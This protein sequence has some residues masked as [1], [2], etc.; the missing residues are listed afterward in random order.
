[1]TTKSLCAALL[2]LA[3]SGCEHA[4]PPPASPTSAA[5][6]PPSADGASPLGF[7]EQVALG[8][9]LYQTHCAS[10][11]GANGEGRG[12]IAAVIGLGKGALPLEPP[13]NAMHRTTEF[14]TILDVAEF[15][16]HSMPASAPGSLSPEEYWSI[17]A[18]DLEANGMSTGG[19]RLD[20]A[21]SGSLVIVR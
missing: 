8:K 1:M 7:P 17:L 4:T 21:L 6:L 18:F 16:V 15:V 10:C 13:P 9:T 14:K 2:A 20:P 11:H 12:R 5:V 3:V 19:K